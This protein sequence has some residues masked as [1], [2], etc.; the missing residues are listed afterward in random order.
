LSPCDEEVLSTLA[1][2]CRLTGKNGGDPARAER[3][4]TLILELRAYACFPTD[5]R[6]LPTPV[7]QKSEYEAPEEGAVTAVELRALRIFGRKGLKLSDLKGEIHRA[8]AAAPIVSINGM[9]VKDSDVL[10]GTEE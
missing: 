8:A 3:L 1:Q 9:I 5:A 4:E 2:L 7:V 6:N 10:G